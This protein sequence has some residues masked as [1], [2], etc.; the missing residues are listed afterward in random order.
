MVQRGNP[1]PKKKKPVRERRN[2]V[3]RRVEMEKLPFA[4]VD[5]KLDAGLDDVLILHRAWRGPNTPLAYARIIS[6]GEN[7]YIVLHDETLGQQFPFQLG[8]KTAEQ[9]TPHLRI[10][11]RAPRPEQPTQ[12]EVVSPPDGSTAGRTEPQAS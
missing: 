3:S 10:F 6:I 7:G 4:I 1:I 9:L 11:R 12:S 8:T 5:G 2:K